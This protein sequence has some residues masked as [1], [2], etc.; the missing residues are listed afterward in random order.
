YAAPA[1]RSGDGVVILGDSAGFVDVPSL[2]GIHYAMQSG[3][4]AA[5]AI[6][7]GLKTGDA[8]AARLAEYD[9]L[10]NA[11]F[12]MK[13]L[14]RT[15][16]MRLA[17]KDGFYTGGVKAALMT[18]TGGRFPGGKIAMEPDAAVERL[19]N[20]AS[21][22][23]PATPDG[24]LSFSKVDAVFKAGNASPFENVSQPSGVAGPGREAGLNRRSTAA[25]GSIAI[26][27]PGN[28]PP[29][30]VISAALTPPA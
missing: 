27:P 13:D 1:R 29:V 30:S 3:M 2:K 19:F 14:H 16:N 4:L 7:A 15:R 28:R 10:V 9:R 18:L 12:I 5:R 26:F 23:G 17:F 6:H 21:R 24:R 25:S 20:P 11:S 22:P 8:S